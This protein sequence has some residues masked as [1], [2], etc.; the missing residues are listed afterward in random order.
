[1]S[2]TQLSFIREWQSGNF[3]SITPLELGLVAAL[4]VFLSRGV[5]VSFFRLL[6]LLGMLHMALQHDRQQTILALCGPLIW[7]KPMAEALA[8]GAAVVDRKDFRAALPAILGAALLVCVL[9]TIRFAHP[10]RRGDDVM[11]PITALAHVPANVKSQP[12]FNDYP[13]GGYLIFTGLKPFIDSRA[14]LYGDPFLLRYRQMVVPDRNM[15]AETLRRY[16]VA[17]VL[18]QPANGANRYFDTAPDWRRVYVDQFAIVYIRGD[19][20]IR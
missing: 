5:R 18:L 3:A 8:D 13:F 16:H 12:V 4:Y 17:W 10:L 1:M 19:V 11:S 9:A 15:L 6:L 20:S 14:D 7:A 2:M